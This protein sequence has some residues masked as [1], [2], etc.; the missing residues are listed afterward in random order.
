[1]DVVWESIQI[2]S[3]CAMW[4]CLYIGDHVGSIFRDS[5]CSEA[6]VEGELMPSIV[7]INTL[8]LVSTLFLWCFLILHISIAVG[9]SLRKVLVE[10]C[11][12]TWFLSLPAANWNVFGKFSNSFEPPPVAVLPVGFQ[13]LH[14]YCLKDCG[15]I[16]TTCTS[17]F[18][19]PAVLHWPSWDC[20]KWLVSVGTNCLACSC[21]RLSCL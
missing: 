18:A 5:C 19:S 8:V 21:N 7:C 4:Y 12:F 10:R 16:L 13:V 2:S 15:V 17:S 3:I 11:L 6:S 9:K 20:S 1:M 14:L